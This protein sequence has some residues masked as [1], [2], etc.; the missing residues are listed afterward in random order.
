MSRWL[1]EGASRKKCAGSGDRGKNRSGGEVV[2]GKGKRK[3][4]GAGGVYLLV[5]AA[6]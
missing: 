1:I 4:F 3:K 6:G 5:Q 2:S